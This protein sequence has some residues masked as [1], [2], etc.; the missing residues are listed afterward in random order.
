[1]L[2]PIGAKLGLAIL[3]AGGR[4]LGINLASKSGFPKLGACAS[5]LIFSH[6]WYWYPLVM[7]LPLT[8]SPNALIGIDEDFWV[9]IN[10]KIQ[11]NSKKSLFDYPPFIKNEENK[12]EKAEGPV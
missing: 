12:K 7:F 9:P 8:M 11:C 6:Y 2:S 5:M 4:N 10:F 1:M 3:Q